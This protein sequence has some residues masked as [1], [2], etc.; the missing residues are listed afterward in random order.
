MT[1]T[2][3]TSELVGLLG[4]AAPFASQDEELPMLNVV[5]LEWDG[6]QLHTMSTDQFRIAWS[7]WDPD[8]DPDSPRQDS[9]FTEWGGD[10]DPWHVY[11]RLSDV[12]DIVSAY[13]L[14]AKQGGTPLALERWVDAEGVHLTIERSSL[15]GHSSITMVVR[16]VAVDPEPDLRGLLARADTITA[17]QSLAYTAGLLADFARVRQRGPLRLTFTGKTK[18][19][20]VE[21]GQR[22]VGAIQPVK[23]EA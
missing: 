21:I 16:A 20:L 9:L 22:F 13:K 17:V 6:S 5:R 18:L 15:T 8:D 23:E 7:T 12:K 4:D 1:V 2:I 19:T 10:D 14:P 3:P 11:V